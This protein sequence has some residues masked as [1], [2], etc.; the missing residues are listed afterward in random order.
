MPCFPY[1]RVTGSVMTPRSWP[2]PSTP[3][4]VPTPPPVPTVPLTPQEGVDVYEFDK[5]SIEANG[6]GIIPGGFSNAEPGTIAPIDFTEG[7][8]VSSIDKKGIARVVLGEI[9]GSVGTGVAM[10]RPIS[11]V[12]LFNEKEEIIWQAPSP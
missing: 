5:A 12:V 4:Q 7:R 1:F 3:T 10:T 6:W 11:S 2:A 9:S 8:I